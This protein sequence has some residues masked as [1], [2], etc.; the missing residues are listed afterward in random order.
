MFRSEYGNYVG[1]SYP[2]VTNIVFAGDGFD[3]IGNMGRFPALEA[4]TIPD[5]VQGIGDGAFAGCVNL[6][7][8]V[9]PDSAEYVGRDAFM[10][11]LSLER[12]VV[13]SGVEYVGSPLFVA[14]DEA[15]QTNILG[16][17]SLKELV[18]ASPAFY[19]A[20]FRNEYGNWLGASY[21]AVT[22]V[23]FGWQFEDVPENVGYVFPSL[24]A[25]TV[26]AAFPQINS[27]TES[28]IALV[29]SDVLKGS[30]DNGLTNITDVATYD[31][32][33]NWAESVGADGQT[34]NQTLAMVKKS[35]NAWLSFA[36]GTDALINK[37]LS[38]D[39]VKINSFAPDIENGQFAF[40][41]S[42]DGVDIGSGS[43]AETLLK[44]NLKKA[45]GVE[46]ATSLSPDAFSPDN[47]EISFDT[48]Q[49]GKAR[50]T[51]T[52]P[53]HAGNSFFMRVKVK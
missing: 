30:R 20:M 38:S 14:W 33:V 17:A 53:A 19:D 4:V 27:G 31:A 40:E 5:V 51:A 37:E 45:L 23:V 39:D 9:I 11:C 8:V 36:L 7:E 2:A 32:F 26:E 28:E 24:V 25:S 42:I 34:H 6:R 10:D 3:F 50:F 41:V 48:P 49:N 44:A 13:G 29:L 43:V 35:S 12:L 15:G 46:G 21:P 16:S 18:V 1:A 52:P 47:I 22:N